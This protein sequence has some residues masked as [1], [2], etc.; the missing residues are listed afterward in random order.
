MHNY[1][2]GAVVLVQQVFTQ[3]LCCFLLQAVEEVVVVEGLVS[4]PQQLLELGQ[5]TRVEQRVQAQLIQQLALWRNTTQ[6]QKW[7]HTDVFPA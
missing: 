3:Y 2:T 5:L 1:Q 7:G 6:G 4:P